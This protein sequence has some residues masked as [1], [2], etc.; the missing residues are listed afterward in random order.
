MATYET[1]SF[2]SGYKFGC[3]TVLVTVGTRS[4]QRAMSVPNDIHSQELIV[5]ILCGEENETGLSDICN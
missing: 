3:S 4:G 2:P 1:L 5:S